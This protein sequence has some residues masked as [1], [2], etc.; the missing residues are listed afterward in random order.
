MEK[1][2]TFKKISLEMLYNAGLILF[3]TYYW[4]VFT[5]VDKKYAP[6]QFLQVAIV[7]FFLKLILTV[8]NMKE[9]CI[10]ACILGIALLCWR[11][12]GSYDFLISTV[13]AL[14]LKDVDFTRTLKIILST[15]I[16]AASFVV[17]WNLIY[18]ITGITKIADFGRGGVETRFRF[19][20]GHPNQTHFMFFSIVTSFLCLYYRRMQWWIGGILLVLNYECYL[21]TKS[22][23]GLICTM[24]AIFLFLTLRYGEKVYHYLIVK[25][26][27]LFAV[28]ACIGFSLYTTF[29]LKNIDVFQSLNSKFTGRLE[30]ARQYVNQYGVHM[31]GVN[32][33]NMSVDLGM[34]RLIVEYGPLVFCIIYGGV[35]FAVW[36]LHKQEKYNL[37]L[38]LVGYV[39]Y[40]TVEAYFQCAFDLK[41]FLIAYGYYLWSDLSGS[42][43]K[44]KN[45]RRLLRNKKGRRIL[46]GERDG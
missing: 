20:W 38:L 6:E 15:T 22:K 16:L 13:V 5:Q 26:I 1:V 25:F 11:T 10:G 12:S 14:G 3:F 35:L 43:R 27:S 7:L 18:N 46:Q 39:V 28:L 4:I 41:P 33:N 8:Y 29:F 36:Q 23:T 40:F 42:K 21:L 45:K 37:L 2:L 31:L 17:T 32:V 44:L 34:I 19:G 30:L 24:G 9:Y